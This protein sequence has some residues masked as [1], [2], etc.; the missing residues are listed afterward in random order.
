MI[1]KPIRRPGDDGGI[2]PG[3]GGAE[4]KLGDAQ[5]H[6]GKH[7]R[8]DGAGAAGDETHAVGAREPARDAREGVLVRA[9]PHRQHVVVP[10][11]G[12][13]RVRGAPLGPH[14]LDLEVE[15]ADEHAA[16]EGED[17]PEGEVVLDVEGHEQRGGHPDAVVHAREGD[18]EREDDHGAA[19]L[20][21]QGPQGRVVG[22]VGHA[23]LVALCEPV[24]DG[25]SVYYLGSCPVPELVHQVI[26]VRRG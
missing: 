16:E 1:P 26:E 11:A 19:E 21:G 5:D 15:V 4:V 12:A 18:Q 10:A 7:E 23:G 8:R 22:V 25:V 2:S 24:L 17:G 9:G 3:H 14:L 20:D 6:E 13:A